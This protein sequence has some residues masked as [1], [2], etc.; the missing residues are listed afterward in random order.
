MKNTFAVG[1][2]VRYH[3][4]FQISGPD[5][6]YVKSPKKKSKAY[7]TSGDPWET[8]LANADSL[9]IGT[10]EWT[11]DKQIPAAA[12]P[13]S[14]AKVKIVLNLFDTAGG[15]LLDSDKK[16]HGFSIAP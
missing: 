1:Q 8:K 2:D 6:Y 3:V 11:W 12:T 4:S 13:G 14:S 10:Y 5:T 15:T 7:N 16:T 9:S